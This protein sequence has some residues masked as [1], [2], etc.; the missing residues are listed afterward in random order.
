MKA[1]LHLSAAWCHMYFSNCSLQDTE[2]NVYT[3]YLYPEPS[4]LVRYEWVQHL[5]KAAQWNREIISPA[6][7]AG[8]CSCTVNPNSAIALFNLWNKLLSFLVWYK[9]TGRGN[10]RLEK[11]LLISDK[12]KCNFSKTS[13]P[14]PT[15][16]EMPLPTFEVGQS[17]LCHLLL[18]WDS[19]TKPVL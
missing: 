3:G 15:V 17:L 10:P 16:M 13:L 9:L 5:V 18:T 2:N 8:W 19:L 1:R 11:L 6:L 14:R 12:R 4:F 7:V